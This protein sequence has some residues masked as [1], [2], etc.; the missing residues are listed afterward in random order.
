MTTTSNKETTTVAQDAGL[1][2]STLGFATDK[3]YDPMDNDNVN[4]AAEVFGNSIPR[5]KAVAKGLKGGSLYRVFKAVMEFPLQDGEPKFQSKI[6][7]ELFILCLSATMAK[8]TMMQAMAASRAKE[9]R[10]TKAAEAAMNTELKQLSPEEMTK[11]T[12]EEA[13]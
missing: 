11:Q 10:E 5:I 12:A 6:E 13:K 9:E 3:P 8:S 2:V 4:K 7:N 1:D